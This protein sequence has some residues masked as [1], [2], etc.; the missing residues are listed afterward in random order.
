MKFMKIQLSHIHLFII[1]LLGLI[2]STTLGK[3]VREGLTGDSTDDPIHDNTPPTNNKDVIAQRNADTEKA[4]SQAKASEDTTAPNFN[5][6]SGPVDRSTLQPN[7]VGGSPSPSGGSQPAAVS[8]SNI[9]PGE[10]DLYMLKSE[11]VPPVCPACPAIK[12]CPRQEQCPPC[13]ACTRCPEPSFECK[14]VPKYDA[15]DAAK[16]P[17]PI[18]SD[19]SQ[20][21]M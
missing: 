18:L 21:G 2:L 7:D 8:G 20:F 10:E 4:N 14:K 11:I 1:L 12:A 17:R 9:L 3:F 15:A 16:I 5:L 19:F 6:A 13:P